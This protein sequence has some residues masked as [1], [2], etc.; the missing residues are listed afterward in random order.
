[1]KIATL[2]DHSLLALRPCSCS[3]EVLSSVKLRVIRVLVQII[4]GP[5]PP[6]V[7]CSRCQFIP[8]S[9]FDFHDT[10]IDVYCFH[11]A[12]RSGVGKAIIKRLSSLRKQSLLPARARISRV[13]G[14]VFVNLEKELWLSAN[15]L[16]VEIKSLVS[17]KKIAQFPCFIRSFCMKSVS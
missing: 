8:L 9:W 13:G 15:E 2:L 10:L 4:H 3:V 17:F 1:M 5:V 11:L 7:K 12:W 14:S 16:L 6:F